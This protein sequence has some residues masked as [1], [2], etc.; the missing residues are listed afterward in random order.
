M[1]KQ[2]RFVVDYSTFLEG[3]GE[4]KS[5]IRLRVMNG[6]I[7]L[8]VKK[9]KFGGFAREEAS[10]FLDESDLRNAFVFMALLGFKKGVTALRGIERYEAD[11][12]EFAIQDVSNL[13]KRMKFTVDSMRRRSWQIKIHLK[14]KR[15]IF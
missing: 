12:V 14:R 15:I 5:D 3:I 4:R 6:K 2:S 1:K 11:G 9:G 7:E 8:I 10:V 13:I